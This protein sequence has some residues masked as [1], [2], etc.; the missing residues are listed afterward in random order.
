MRAAALILAAG[1]A[2]AQSVEPMAPDEFLAA[3]EGATL[4]FERLGDGAPFGTEEFLGRG[5]TRYVMADGTCTL[6]VATPRD[7]ALCFAYPV[8][9]GETCWW[10]F[11]QGE[12]L[13]ARSARLGAADI[14][15]VVEISDDPVVCDAVPSV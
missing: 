7:G 13:L 3:V 4:T 11:R 15:E 1:T 5:R 9:E 10:M 12:R 2:S 8:V 14:V 6:G